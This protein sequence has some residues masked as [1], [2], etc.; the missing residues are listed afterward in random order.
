MTDDNGGN[1]QSIFI[2]LCFFPK[3]L[4]IDYVFKRMYEFDNKAPNSLTHVGGLT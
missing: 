3:L 4:N 1:N 2:T